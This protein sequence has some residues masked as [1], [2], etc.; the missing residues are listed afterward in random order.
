[1]V[2]INC[3]RYAENVQVFNLTHLLSIKITLFQD[4][5]QCSLVNRNISNENAVLKMILF[6]VVGFEY[7]S[8]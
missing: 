5:T 4:V 3:L 6:Y 2:H 1:M 8:V 7:T